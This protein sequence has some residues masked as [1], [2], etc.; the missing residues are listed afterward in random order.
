MASRRSSVQGNP[1]NQL[2]A[3]A[4]TVAFGHHEVCP[5]LCSFRRAQYPLIE[6]YSDPAVIGMKVQENLM[7]KAFTENL[8]KHVK[9]EIS[10]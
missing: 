1:K 8:Q 7:I 4:L 9:F 2:A 10:P 5:K 6:G 3:V